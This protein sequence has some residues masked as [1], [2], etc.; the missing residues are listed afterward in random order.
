MSGAEL[1]KAIEKPAIAVPLSV[2]LAVGTVLGFQVAVPGQRLESMEVRQAATTHR[3]D[4]L[5]ARFESYVRA[6]A[7]EDTLMMGRF[8]P[9]YVD[10]CLNRSSRETDMM[11]L[12]CDTLIA[13]ARGAP[14]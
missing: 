12:R 2:V 7:R 6:A 13:R 3:V 1:K 8:R 5:Q 4:T 14:K 10:L 11:G 9:L